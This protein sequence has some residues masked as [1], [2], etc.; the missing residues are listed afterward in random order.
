MVGVVGRNRSVAV[1]P[2]D[3]AAGGGQP[4]G[5]VRRSRQRVMAVAGRDVEA[6][7]RAEHQA[8]AVM[9]V[10]G[11][12][13]I[14]IQ[15]DLGRQVGGVAR[16]GEPRHRVPKGRRPRVEDVVVTVGREVRVERQVDQ[17]ALSD[18]R[19]D[20]GQLQ[21]RHRLVVGPAG[22]HDA[23]PSR[24]LG[25]DQPTVGNDR[26]RG[27][28]GEADEDLVV[29]EP[30]RRRRGRGRWR[31]RGR[32]R[33]RHNQARGQRGT[34]VE[35]VDELPAPRAV[36]AMHDKRGAAG[37]APVGVVHH[38]LE[39]GPDLAEQIPRVRDPRHVRGVRHEPR[40]QR[41]GRGP[42]VS[43]ERR[44][45]RTVLDPDRHA[46]GQPLRLRS[47]HLETSRADHRVLRDVQLETQSCVA[48]RGRAPGADPNR[49]VELVDH[50]AHLGHVVEGVDHLVGRGDRIGCAGFDGGARR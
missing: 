40:R 22:Q 30:G 6:S 36:G 9:D 21:K 14:L 18:D 27:R 19:L 47:V 38:L 7:V 42:G 23:D 24:P 2:Q 28:L 44:D 50:A 4:L 16:G 45:A 1:D 31:R 35:A 29:A 39:Q 32:R 10:G 48:A 20:V 13:G 46:D 25:H 3:F 33:I 17:C 26:D 34:A 37:R 12:F 15:H 8:A 5:G 41:A 43:R 11:Q 49:R